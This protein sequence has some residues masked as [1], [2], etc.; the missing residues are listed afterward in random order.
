MLKHKQ[1][2]SDLRSTIIKPGKLLW[3]GIRSA[4]RE[5]MFMPNSA[6][7][8][9][10]HG[11]EGDH[12]AQKPG[13]K[14]QI[15]L[16]QAEHIPVIQQLANRKTLEPELLRRNLVIA[17]INLLALKDQQFSIGDAV[18]E[19][20]GPC[21]PCSRMEETLGKGGYNAVRGH[22]GITA[23]IIQGGNITIGDLVYYKT[24]NE[25]P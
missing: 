12:S 4:H 7:L 18:L 9:E 20:T 14:R 6:F 10:N 25:K 24:R 16:I 22:G 8:I 21:A 11:V 3:I 23:R 1:T 19:G 5:A 15:S 17:G 13:K 2:L